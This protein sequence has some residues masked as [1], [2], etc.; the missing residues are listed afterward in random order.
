MTLLKKTTGSS[1]ASHQKTE[2]KRTRKTIK[3]RRT[4][5]GNSELETL[6]SGKRGT[7]RET[8]PF[9]LRFGG[10]PLHPG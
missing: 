8:L 4:K 10:A 1:T 6:Y 9:L 3:E 7:E 5:R 2:G